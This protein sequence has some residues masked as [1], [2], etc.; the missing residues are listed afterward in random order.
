MRATIIRRYGTMRA[1]Y[2]RREVSAGVSISQD[3]CGAQKPVDLIITARQENDKH[4][5]SENK[6]REKYGSTNVTILDC[7]RSEVTEEERAPGAV[8][9]QVEPKHPVGIDDASRIS[10]IN[11]GYT[12]PHTESPH[13]NAAEYSNISTSAIKNHDAGALLLKSSPI[14]N[15]ATLHE[16]TAKSTGSEDVSP[17]LDIISSEEEDTNSCSNGSQSTSG[18]SNPSSLWN[19]QPTTP[20]REEALSGVLDPWR[21]SM[22]DRLMVDLHRLFGRVAPY[23][24][25]NSGSSS[26]KSTSKSDGDSSSRIS[27]GAPSSSHSDTCKRPNERGNEQ[28]DGE[29]S[30]PEEDRNPKK[31]R[32][33]EE[34]DPVLVKFACPYY[35][36]SPHR[37]KTWKSCSAPGFASI[38]RLK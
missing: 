27:T 17:I 28:D 21:N 14:E 20:E 25:R 7:L 35:K 9:D 19:E 6:D 12:K 8:S 22:I 2:P 37:H 16:R 38:H 11:N 10:A 1:T 23:N 4:A 34:L 15:V 18:D 13:K 30:D 26:S 29:A 5:P 3:A 33:S 31:P 36:R 24:E 32:P